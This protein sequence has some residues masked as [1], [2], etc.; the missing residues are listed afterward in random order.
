MLW[1]TRTLWCSFLWG[2]RTFA[3]KCFANL[4]KLELQKPLIN[5]Q[6]FSIPS[7]M[8]TLWMLSGQL[9]RNELWLRFQELRNSPGHRNSWTVFHNWSV[10]SRLNEH[11]GR[12]GHMKESCS[13]LGFV[14]FFFNGSCLATLLEHSFGKEI[15]LPN[16][17]WPNRDPTEGHQLGH[18]TEETAQLTSSMGLELGVLAQ[19]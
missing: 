3:N 10:S 14:S 5:F 18:P 19:M 2:H 13:L 17:K 4:T 6:S 8:A 7:W 1:K 16:G 12:E 15:H 11:K 9:L